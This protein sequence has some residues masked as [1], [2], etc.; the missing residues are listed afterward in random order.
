MPE[1]D[2]PFD[3]AMRKLTQREWE[4]LKSQ[5]CPLTPEQEARLRAAVHEEFAKPQKST[6]PEVPWWSGFWSLL[7]S[8][9]GY[10]VSATVLVLFGLLLYRTP[11]PQREMAALPRPDRSFSE[12]PRRLLLEPKRNRLELVGGTTR[13][14]GRMKAVPNLSLPGVL[15][16]T[17]NLSGTDSTGL[18]VWI[19]SLAWVTNTPGMTT[20]KN[21]NDVRGVL[22]QGTL[23]IP[24]R[25]TNAFEQGYAP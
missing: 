24:G 3:A 5:R 1:N 16:F 18:E 7:R 6:A 15:V 22:L 20:I 17:N 10:A 21:I 8:P 11:G 4:E 12:L 25:S 9:I 13:F 19:R 14:S 2:H 23:E